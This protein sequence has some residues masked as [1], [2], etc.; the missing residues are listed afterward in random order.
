MNA[1][2]M[3]KSFESHIPKIE[4]ALAYSFQDKKLLLL[5]FVH[6]SFINENREWVTEHNERLEFLGDAILG[7]FV[8]DFLYRHF[9]DENEGKL[10]EQK[11]HLV[12]ASACYTYMQKIE[13]SSFILMGKGELLNEGKARESIQADV[14]EALIGAIYLDGGLESAR[15]FFFGHFHSEMHKLLEK[16]A[17]NWKA[18]LQDVTQREHR[19]QP[20][21]LVTNEEG[22]D[23]CKIFHVV[24]KVGD[25]E[26]GR[27]S[28]CSKKM[29]QQEA[30]QDALTHY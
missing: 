6:R 5:S 19:M 15:R 27:G 14:F 12:D 11:A 13:I 20:E 7:F 16:P 9:P 8:S 25:K 30:A 23:H 18:E 17:R 28:G 21:Y 1:M 29:A 24:V 4:E 2:N 3:L 26:L 10:S 22:P